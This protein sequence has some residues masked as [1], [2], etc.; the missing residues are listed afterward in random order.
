MTCIKFH[1]NSVWN[2]ADHSENAAGHVYGEINKTEI[3]TGRTFPAN[4]IRVGSKVDQSNLSNALIEETTLEDIIFELY[5]TNLQ[6]TVRIEG[7]PIRDQ[8]T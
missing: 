8:T 5:E 1:F 3:L 6:Q 4:S 7:K 2:C